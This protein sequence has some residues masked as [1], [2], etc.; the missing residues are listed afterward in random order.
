MMKEDH[1]KY[2]TPEIKERAINAHEAGQTITEI[3]RFYNTHRTTIHRWVNRY[4]ADQSFERKHSPGSGRPPTLN[5]ND[6]QQVIECIK[7]PATAFGYETDF[8]TLRRIIEV[9]KKELG[10]IISKTAMYEMLY[11]NDF[12]YKKPEQRYYEADAQ[13]QKKWVKDTIPKINKCIQ[14]NKAILYFEDESSIAMQPVIG[15]TWGRIGE[16]TIHR[17]TA[18]R[19]SIAA[20]SAIS[21]SGKLI[22]TLHEQK[23]TSNEIIHFLDQMLQHHPRRHLAVVIDNAPSHTSKA[24]RS[25]ISSGI[26]HRDSNFF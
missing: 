3:S 14:E 24:T 9:T 16:K 7:K 23:I 25:F 6:I 21:P 20:M 19:G 12:S 5:N 10:I 11:N 18:N 22:F 26:P 8:W 13:E 4:Q 2:S 15:K 1:M 17:T